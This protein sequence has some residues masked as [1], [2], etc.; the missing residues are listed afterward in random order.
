MKG[1][2]DD[3]RSQ[4]VLGRESTSIRNAFRTAPKGTTQGQEST[5]ASFGEKHITEQAGDKKD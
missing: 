1:T 4:W 3:V 5:V 2:I